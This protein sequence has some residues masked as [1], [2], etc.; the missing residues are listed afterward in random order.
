LKKFNYCLTVLLLL[1]ILA[2][3]YS[4][5]DGTSTGN[6][7]ITGYKIA[8]VNG[9]TE[10]KTDSVDTQ[11]TATAGSFDKTT[12]D[13]VIWKAPATS[14]VYQVSAKSGVLTGTVNI[15]VKSTPLIITGWE[16]VPD[17]IGGKDI[18][19]TVQNNGSKTINAFRVYIVMWN[20][21]NE[22][23][24][25]LGEDIFSG[26]ASDVYI[27]PGNSSVHT[28]SLYWATGVTKAL[29]W[30]YQIAYTDGTTWNLYE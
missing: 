6:V 12:G 22:R 2:G 15:T 11:W 17:S 29:P 21:F 14:G 24:D 1:V 13:T 30:V 4:E 10:L 20:N 7:T 25:Y 16:L 5:P 3:C 28:W 19:I 9:A 27:Q 18:K 26:I 23:V 8:A